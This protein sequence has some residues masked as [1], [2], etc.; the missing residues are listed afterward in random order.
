MHIELS[1]Y[2]NVR[3]MVFILCVIGPEKSSLSAQFILLMDTLQLHSFSHK[4]AVDDQV[5]FSRQQMARS[6]SHS[7]M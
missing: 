2:F 4:V 7:V 6:Q 1:V 5:Y 3:H